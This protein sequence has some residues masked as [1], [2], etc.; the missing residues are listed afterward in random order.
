M[1][2][3]VYKLV[4]NTLEQQGCQDQQRGSNKAWPKTGRA[5]PRPN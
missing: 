2:D 1:P 5:G 3:V 4:V